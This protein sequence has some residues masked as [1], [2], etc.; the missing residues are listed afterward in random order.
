M[1]QKTENNTYFSKINPLF[2]FSSLSLV[3]VLL[4][5][6]SMNCKK[7]ATDP[8]VDP[9]KSELEK[10][11]AITTEGKN[12]FGCLVNGKAWIPESNF[13]GISEMGAGY[14]KTDKDLSIDATI[15]T[16]D[17]FESFLI[18]IQPINHNTIDSFQLVEQIAFKTSFANYTLIEPQKPSFETD[19]LTTGFCHILRFDSTAS[20]VSGTFYFKA[21]N[22][23]GDSVEITNGRF[24][25]HYA[26]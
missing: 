1:Y 18:T 21:K 3:L 11:P 2:S 6:S 4:L 26:Q 16:K 10:L 14:S 23:K 13:S 7:P 17:I 8:P 9:I 24:D 19:S 20:I 25:I 22:Q 12:T 15:K 5:F